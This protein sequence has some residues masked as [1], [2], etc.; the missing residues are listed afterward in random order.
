SNQL[1][2]IEKLK[3]TPLLEIHFRKLAIRPIETIYLNC[4]NCGTQKLQT[5]FCPKCEKKF[6]VDNVYKSIEKGIDINLAITLLLDALKNS[7]DVA[8]L[9][10]GDADFIPVIDYV[11]NQLH[12]EIVYCYFPKFKT[13]ELIQHCS[14]IRYILKEIIQKSR[15]F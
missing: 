15:P 8:L 2:F 13:S 1:K 3:K 5:I 10:S 11:R 7:Y 6:S 4:S 9:F 12:K 14:S